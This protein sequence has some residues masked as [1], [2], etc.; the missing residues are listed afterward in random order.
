MK[1]ATQDPI[2]LT[3]L[4]HV[5]GAL[6]DIFQSRELAKGRA[7]VGDMKLWCQRGER[8][9]TGQFR[10][11]VFDGSAWRTFRLNIVADTD[12]RYDTLDGRTTKAKQCFA[13]IAQLKNQTARLRQGSYGCTFTLKASAPATAQPVAP[14]V[15]TTAAS[16]PET[17]A[18]STAARTSQT[19][20]L[21]TGTKS[22]VQATGRKRKRKGSDPNQ[23]T[24][25]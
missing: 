3:G 21:G 16:I 15:P 18:P 25:F 23:L 20:A 9:W 24:L 8:I 2:V 5:S 14:A 1:Q 19:P 13:A 6:A 12:A 22:I 10:A 11:A 17:P 4:T 7:K